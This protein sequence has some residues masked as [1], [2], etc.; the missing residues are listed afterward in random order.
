MITKEEFYEIA[1]TMRSE[2]H[3][4][5]NVGCDNTE[6]VKK[7]LEKY[8]HGVTGTYEYAL[9]KIIDIV[10]DSV[11]IYP[12]DQKEADAYCDA[13][14]ARIDEVVASIAAA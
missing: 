2:C 6:P 1:K 10:I 7:N 8:L 5:I 9:R 12:W 13:F 14:D 4:I 3:T 11:G